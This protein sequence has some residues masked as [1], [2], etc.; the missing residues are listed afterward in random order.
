MIYLN[1]ASILANK[2]RSRLTLINF[3][4]HSFEISMIEVYKDCCKNCL[5]SPDSIVSPA[6]RKD[7][8]QDC[9]RQQTH[10]ICHKATIE[11]KDILCKTFFDKLGHI[12]QMVRIAERLNCIEFVEQPEQ[13]KMVSWAEMEGRKRF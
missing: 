12:S 5:L 9:K 10:F 3:K 2:T 8:I 6:R 13:T 11:G 7:I 1:N 4:Y